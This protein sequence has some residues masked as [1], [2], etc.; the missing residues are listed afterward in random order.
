MSENWVSSARFGRW[1]T[2]KSS[3]RLNPGVLFL[4]GWQNGKPS[5]DHS[6]AILT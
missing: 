4:P 1:D 6:E 5:V 3:V 2:I